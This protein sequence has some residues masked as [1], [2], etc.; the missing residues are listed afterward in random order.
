[1]E[2]DQIYDF[3]NPNSKMLFWAVEMGPCQKYRESEQALSSLVYIYY[4][5]FNITACF[6]YTK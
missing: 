2:H 4:Q 1:M 6:L 5:N 3:A